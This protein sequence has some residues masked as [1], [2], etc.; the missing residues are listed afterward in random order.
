MKRNWKIKK[1]IYFLLLGMVMIGF[2]A[3]VE[4]KSMDKQFRSIEVHVQ[5]IRDVYFV[6][7][8]EV[9][10]LLQNEFSFLK[11]GS[12]LE[13]ISLGTI[14]KRIEHHPFVKNSEVFMDLKG[15]VVVKIEQHRPVAR[16]IRPMAPH[17]Y[18]SAEGEILPTSANY[19]SRV[20]TLDGPL[21]E[22]LLEEENL[23]SKHGDLMELIHFIEG[24]NFW[25]AQIPGLQIDRKGNIILYQQVGRQVIEFGKP[26]EIEEKFKRIAIFYKEILPVKGW[27]F[28]ERVNV[29]F[30]D[31]IICE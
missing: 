12:P 22:E 3:F 23:N 19:T 6:D 5:G 20:L 7:E 21:A 29:K 15:T 30:K 4:R 25:S 18:I 26:T 2:I 28:Y 10:S 16:I 9:V 13:E 31:Q 27:D 17:G 24:N 11:P 14:E 8:A 1:S